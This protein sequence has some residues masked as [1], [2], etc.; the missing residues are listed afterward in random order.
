MIDDLLPCVILV[1]SL[2]RSKRLAEVARNIHEAT[3][4]PHDILFCVGEP[5]SMQALDAVG[6]R[7]ID[8]TDDPDKRYVT[9]MNK[10]V[11]AVR[12]EDK[13]RTVFFGSDDVLHRR[14]WLT[15]ALRVMDTGP[16]VVVVNDLHNR[17]GTQAVMAVD[18]TIEAVFDAPGDAFHHGYQHNFADD[19]QFFTAF[20]KG[21]YARAM[22]SI[23]EH[24]HPIW[25]SPRSLRWD[26]TYINARTNWDQDQALFHERAQMIDGTFA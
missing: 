10:L 12:Y 3:P 13:A 14:G 23:V 21:V 9:R 7:Y 26:S 11:R 17:M 4:E 20:H 24:L 1:P 15:E 18:Y 2:G 5:E 22:N 6:E 16:R 19:E 25:G 8:D